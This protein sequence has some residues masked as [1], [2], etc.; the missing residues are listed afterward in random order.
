[1]TRAAAK[2]TAAAEDLLA[3]LRSQPRSRVPPPHPVALL[4]GPAAENPG[5]DILRDVPG[6]D[7]PGAA[8]PAPVPSAPALDPFVG[9]GE[10]AVRPG[11]VPE[12]ADRHAPLRLAHTDWLHHRLRITGPTAAL[13][14]FRD[15]APAPG[16]FPGSS[17]PTAWRQSS[18]FSARFLRSPSWIATLRSQ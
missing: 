9:S 18:F 16:P 11:G 8:A 15:A 5:A 14:A 3:W 12:H 4:P 13:A 7:S 1:M 2:A 17:T 6:P 10:P